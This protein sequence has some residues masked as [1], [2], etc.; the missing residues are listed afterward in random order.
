MLYFCFE[1]YIIFF[2]SI[3]NPYFTEMDRAQYEAYESEADYDSMEQNPT[4]SKVII[5]ILIN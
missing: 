3:D 1:W 4:V 2:P 5:V